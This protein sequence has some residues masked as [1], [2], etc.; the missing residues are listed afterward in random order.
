[1]CDNFYNYNL[2]NIVKVIKFILYVA[3]LQAFK[4]IQNTICVVRANNS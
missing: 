2:V 4:Y 1:M 3:I